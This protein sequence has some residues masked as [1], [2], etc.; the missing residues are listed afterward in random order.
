MYGRDCSEE[1]EKADVE[2]REAAAASGT[3]DSGHYITLQRHYT[4][5][6]T[7]PYKLIL[8][9]NFI[10]CKILYQF[11]IVSLALFSYNF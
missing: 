2:R 7:T 11:Y 4:P 6:Y 9:T 10:H 3:A 8:Y 1:K 5:L